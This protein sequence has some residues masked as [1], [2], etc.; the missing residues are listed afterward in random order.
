[1]TPCDTCT[2][3]SY[4]SKVKPIR[5]PMSTRY[6]EQ[7]AK[8]ICDTDAG[9]R[10]I[11]A[12][13]NDGK[14]LEFSDMCPRYRIIQNRGSALKSTFYSGE[15]YPTKALF[16][17]ENLSLKKIEPC[18]WEDYIKSHEKYETAISDP[19]GYFQ[20]L[21]RRTKDWSSIYLYGLTGSGKTTLSLILYNMF[22]HTVSVDTWAGS[23][24]IIQERFAEEHDVSSESSGFLDYLCRKRL[25]LIDDIF[26]ESVLS[27]KITS[28]FGIGNQRHN[29]QDDFKE[30]L[31]TRKG[32]IIFTSNF[33]PYSEKKDGREA[34]YNP[35]IIDRM[36]QGMILIKVISKEGSFRQRK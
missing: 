16:P 1:M 18:R 4:I 19:I 20:E 22:M 36:C 17:P 32:K 14:P 11:H 3:R 2:D 8:Y 9:M 21:Y 26:Q 33:S 12:V 25:V 5:L 27:E 15:G 28:G 31:D 23:M 30:Y 24:K 7:L 6:P 10:L 35:R 34:N 13:G 29:F